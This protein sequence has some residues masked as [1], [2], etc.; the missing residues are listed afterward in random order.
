MEGAGFS[1]RADVRLVDLRR[2]LAAEAE[3]R[4]APSS[5]AR[6]VAALKGFL[7]VPARE[8]GP[9]TQPC[10]WPSSRIRVCA[11]RRCWCSIGRTSISSGACFACGT[12]EQ[13]G[14]NAGWIG[15]TRARPPFL[16][17]ASANRDITGALFC[18]VHDRRRSS[19]IVT[20]R[21]LRY[22][23]AAGVTCA[24]A[25][26]HTLRHVFASELLR[27]GA[28]LRQIQELLGHKPLDSTQRYTRVT[29]HELRGMAKRL[30]FP[31]A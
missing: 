18:D 31:R 21:F 20:Q 13:R 4:P 25:T 17:H 30:S 3:H 27:A 28:N 12:L 5:Q 2:F 8:R 7:P 23:R 1:S 29:A 11:T 15:T 10:C 22:A 24:S 26:P 9:R 14:A 19:T 6:T 16:A